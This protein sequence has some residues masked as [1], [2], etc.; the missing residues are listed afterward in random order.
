MK[1]SCSHYFSG[2]SGGAMST[3]AR[4]SMTAIGIARRCRAV[5]L[6]L[7]ACLI[8]AACAQRDSSSDKDPPGGFYGGFSGGMVK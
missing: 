3:G 5:A 7:L 8:V 1:K 6:L 4:F 2:R